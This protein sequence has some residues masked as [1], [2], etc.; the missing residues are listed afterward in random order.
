MRPRSIRF[1]LTA[2]YTAALAITFAAAGLGVWWAIR[3]SIDDTVDRDLRARVR[4]MRNFLATESATNDL[5]PLREELFEEAAIAPAGTQYRLAA[6]D[7]HWTYASAG[8]RNWPSIAPAVSSLRENGTTET[9]AAGGKPYRVI[10]APVP[11]GLVQI[12]IPIDE[13]DEMLRDF[14]S[15][16]L[17]ASPVLLFLAALGGYWMSARALAPIDRMARAA[18]EIEV[19]N[20]SRRL[21]LAGTGDE[22]DRLSGTLNSMFGRLEAAFRRMTQFTADASHELR[23][24]VAIIRT[25]AEICRSQRR[26]GAE[27]EQAL[28]RILAASERTTAL[29]EDLMTLAR[30]D[31]GADGMDFVTVDA[32]VLLAGACADMRVLAETAGLRLE[33]RIEPGCHVFGDEKALHRLFVILLENSIKYTPR[34]G[35]VEVALDGQK[36]TAVLEVRDTGIGIHP[37][38]LPHVFDRFY[39]AAKDRSRDT[40]GAGLGLSI[41]K[42]IAARHGAEISVESALGVG[43][44]FRLQMA[45]LAVRDDFT[46]SSESATKLG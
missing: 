38:D 22:L 17:L 25:T 19:Q 12:G 3:D 9:V 10:S 5:G 6:S 46:F 44:V 2:W 31:G 40:G 34:G 23:T 21:P 24:P 15:S 26:T 11:T 30:A 37:D 20:L 7:G 36:A 13:F 4:A 43:S 18:E 35:K 29:I 16:A 27:Y 41:A 1:R 8:T 45:R 32:S 28:D 42:W 14:T 39:R 33:S